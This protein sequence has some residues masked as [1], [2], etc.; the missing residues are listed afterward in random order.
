M[1]A[2]PAIMAC[3]GLAFAMVAS[4]TE[5]ARNDRTMVSSG[6][7]AAI[8]AANCTACHG[9]DARGSGP[10]A[11]GLS[12][13]PPD[14]TTLSERNGGSFPQAR[15]LSYIYGDPYDSHLAR[16]MPQFGEAMEDELVLVEIEGVVTPTPPELAA[17]LF[18]L[19]DIQ[20]L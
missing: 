14:L 17:L 11:S 2:T 1:R 7:G 13:Q 12:V 19:E 16:V 9:A 4:C 15:A 5:Q 8:F 10:A 6:D 20:R 3:S 18:Y